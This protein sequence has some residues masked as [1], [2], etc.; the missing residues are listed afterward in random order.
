VLINLW[1]GLIV[2]LWAGY[3]LLEGFDFGVGLLYPFMARDEPERKAVLRTIGAVWDGN[4]VWLLVAGGATFAAF[5][6]WYASLFSG[7]Y[8]A[9]ALILVGLILR[10]A[11][12]E[13]RSKA[14]TDSGRAWCDRAFVV[15]SALPALLWGV[16]FANFVRGV[17]INSQHVVDAPLWTLLS[18]YALLGG[19]TSVLLFSS[20]AAHFL[21]LRCTDDLRDRALGFGRVLTP[22]SLVVTAGFVVATWIQ[23]ANVVSVLVSLV[24]AAGLALAL[25]ANRAE[26]EGWAFAGTALTCLLVPVF[27]F[28]STWPYAIV[29]RGSG[30][31]GSSGLTLDAAASSHMTLTVMTVVALVMTPVVLAYQGWTYWIFRQRVSLPAVAVESPVGTA[32]GLA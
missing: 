20:H 27:I 23:R 15:G 29:G 9:L 4:E 26:R 8:L 25:L 1:F 18:P 5:P 13:L 24:A 7:Y 31:S 21:A 22:A 16:A 30:S 19:V 32:S 11:G 2:I 3:V 17:P 14:A 12:I 6:E 28:A 10:G